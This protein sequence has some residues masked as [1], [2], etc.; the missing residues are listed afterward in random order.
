[1]ARHTR[2][3]AYGVAV[4]ATAVSLLARWPLW[5]VLGANAPFI[6]F[7]AAIIFSAYLGG[8]GPGLLATLLSAAAANYFLIEPVHSFWIASAGDAVALTVF[9]LVGTAIFALSE[10]LHRAHR[11]LVADERQRSEQVLQ[12]NEERFRQLAENIRELFW[13]RDAPQEALALRQPSL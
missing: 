2:L 3:V 12:E 4:L 9:V 1:M 6:T 10:S 13:M 11:R 7:F 5:P 8:F